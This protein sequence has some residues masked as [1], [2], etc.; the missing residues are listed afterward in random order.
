MFEVI[1][2]VAKCLRTDLSCMWINLHN[3]PTQTTI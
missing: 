3:W 2:K 1:P